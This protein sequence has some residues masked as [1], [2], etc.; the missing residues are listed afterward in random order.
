MYSIVL[1]EGDQ[2]MHKCTG[3]DIYKIFKNFAEFMFKKYFGR[4]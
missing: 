2:V 1:Y 4:I 3:R